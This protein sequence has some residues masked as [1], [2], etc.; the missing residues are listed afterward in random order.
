MVV[1]FCKPCL[2]LK[3]LLLVETLPGVRYFKVRSFCNVRDRFWKNIRSNIIFL[4]GLNKTYNFNFLFSQ[5]FGTAFRLFETSSPKIH[6][7]QFLRRV[8]F[9]SSQNME[10]FLLGRP[11]H[12][13]IY[14][15]KKSFEAFLSTSQNLSFSIKAN[16]GVFFSGTCR[17]QTNPAPC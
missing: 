10:R 13:V 8:L 5:L 4:P 12:W 17:V 6:R 11:P 1:F 16:F 15:L 9:Q 3:L 7:L 14:K 2:S